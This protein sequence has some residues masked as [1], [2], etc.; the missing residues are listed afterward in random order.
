MSRK[1]VSI[2]VLST[3]T[4]LLLCSGFLASRA[5]AGS[6]VTVQLHG[7]Q[8]NPIYVDA[9]TVTINFSAF[10]VYSGVREAWTGQVANVLVYNT[11][12]DSLATLPIPN[13][14][15]IYRDHGELGT[16]RL[17]S[18]FK[19]AESLTSTASAAAFRSIGST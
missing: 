16:I 12:G 13:A 19:S 15:Q 7:G 10:L 5:P 14:D 17:L 1:L 8:S 18:T 9:G 3:L 6:P 2:R 11:F 4:V